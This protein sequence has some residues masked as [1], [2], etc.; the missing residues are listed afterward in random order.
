MSET[1][2]CPICGGGGYTAHGA[3]GSIKECER[4][5]GTGDV[6]VQTEEEKPEV[7]P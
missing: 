2:T 6:P 7:E 1:V 4:C 5:G 3:F